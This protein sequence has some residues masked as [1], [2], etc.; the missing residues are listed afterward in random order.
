MNPAPDLGRADQIRFHWRV[1]RCHLK[2]IGKHIGK[3]CWGLPGLFR[4]LIGL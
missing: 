3:L 1:I 2:H 4:A